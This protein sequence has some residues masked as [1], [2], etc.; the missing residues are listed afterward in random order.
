MSILDENI[1]PKFE[2]LLRG[3]NWM[4]VYRTGGSISYEYTSVDCGGRDFSIEFFPKGYK[5]EVTKYHNGIKTYKIKKLRKDAWRVSYQINLNAVKESKW[6][7]KYYLFQ[8]CREDVISLM[9][10]MS[11]RAFDPK[12]YKVIKEMKME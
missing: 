6:T 7:T 3:I 4:E 10:N 11:D 9:K 8:T 5:Y 1:E 12:K 2:D